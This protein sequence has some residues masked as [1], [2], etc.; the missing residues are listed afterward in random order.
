M[1]CVKRDAEAAEP[2]DRQTTPRRCDASSCGRS[3]RRCSSWP[4]ASRW[5]VDLR[6]RASSLKIARRPGA[7]RRLR[8]PTSPSARIALAAEPPL[9][10][11]RAASPRMAGSVQQII[12]DVLD[13]YRRATMPT[14]R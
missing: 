14:R 7:H 9:P 4:C 5:P 12:K 2:G 1:R 11:R 13:A 10:P 6:D 8:R 3:S